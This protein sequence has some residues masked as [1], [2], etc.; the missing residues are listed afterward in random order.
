MFVSNL[1]FPRLDEEGDKEKCLTPDND[2]DVINHVITDVIAT[3]EA[4]EYQNKIETNEEHEILS[5]HSSPNGLNSLNSFNF[6]SLF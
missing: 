4:E 2:D 3:E 5:D 1:Y 6:S